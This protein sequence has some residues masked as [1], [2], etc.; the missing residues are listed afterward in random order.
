MKYTGNCVSCANISREDTTLL[1]C[2]LNNIPNEADDDQ[3]KQ[4]KSLTFDLS[5]NKHIEAI[6]LIPTKGIVCPVTPKGILEGCGPYISSI[7]HCR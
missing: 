2:L 1:F 7:H 4:V 6:S 5:T 3:E